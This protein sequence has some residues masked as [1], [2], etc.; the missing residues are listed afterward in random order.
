MNSLLK[1]I[2]SEV[3]FIENY[4]G[5]EIY[6]KREDLIHP[7]ISGNKWR[8]L[9]YNLLE[10]KKQG[11]ST[12]LTFGGAYSNHIAATAAACNKYGFKSI[13]IIRGEEYSD[14]NPTL[15][16]AT[17]N[18]MTLHYVSR[19]DYK[20]KTNADFI[21]SLQQQFGKFYLVPEG[22]DNEFGIKG[23]EEI[24]NSG[25]SKFDIICSA[26][27]TGSTFTG[28]VNSLESHQKGF[29]FPVLK[30]GES[31]EQ[32]I[33]VQAKTL[34][35]Q[36]FHD[37][38]YGGYAKITPELI[39]FINSFYQNHKI[40]LDPVYTGKMAF[41]VYNLINNK[42]ISVNSKVLL[43]HTG[44]LQGAKGIENRYGIKLAY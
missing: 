16:L 41:A 13:G 8:K 24:L 38:H 6:I 4:K 18:G 32:K 1:E 39:A 35:W 26:I 12:I 20:N 11:C 7:E 34:N 40:A 43:I 42:Q 2:K 29:G 17:E 36:V 5:I 21:Q 23:C 33:S 22:G 30:L 19:Q 31:I 9:K 27:G 44:G 25:D 37:A 15:K 10:A 14:L 28:I 3:Q